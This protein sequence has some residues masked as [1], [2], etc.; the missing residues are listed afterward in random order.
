MKSAQDWVKELN[1]CCTDAEET[2][3]IRA[4]QA[5]ALRYAVSIAAE[6]YDKS[7]ALEC[8]NIASK[9]QEQIAAL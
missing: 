6:E 8:E 9:I 1:F 2:K 7:R 3:V 4:I 5:D